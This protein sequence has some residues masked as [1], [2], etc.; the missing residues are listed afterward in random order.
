MRISP[1]KAASSVFGRRGEVTV[2]LRDFP[3]TA[4][5][6]EGGYDP[7]DRGSFL[8]KFKRRNPNYAVSNGQTKTTEMAVGT[9]SNYGLTMVKVTNKESGET[10][11]LSQEQFNRFFDNRNP[12]D[13]KVEN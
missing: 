3:Y 12:A 7:L 11:L 10:M 13:W 5:T 6:D 8:A 1:K 2:S 9:N 4:Q